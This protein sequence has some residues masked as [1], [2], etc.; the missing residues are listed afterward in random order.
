MDSRPAVLLV[1][2]MLIAMAAPTGAVA[3]GGA[4]S[5]ITLT[6]YPDGS[7]G[8][9]F[10]SNETSP[11]S[12]SASVSSF[13]VQASTAP[14][15]GGT[16]LNLQ[17]SAALS[18]SLTSQQPYSGATSFTAT[19]SY[20][21]GVASGSV[22]VQLVPGYS[23][24]LTSFELVYHGTSSSVTMGGNATV[25]YGTYTVNGQQVTVNQSVVSEFVN[26]F[27]QQVNA[28]SLNRELAAYNANVT[29]T[30]VTVSPTYSSNS[31]LVSLQFQATGDIAELPLFYFEAA[32]STVGPSQST[33]VPASEAAVF[34][35]YGEILSSFHDYTYNLAYSSGTASLNIKIDAASNLNIDQAI[36]TLSAGGAFTGETPSQSAFLSAT[37]F[38]ISNFNFRETGTVQTN[39]ESFVAVS[40]SGFLIRPPV[41]VVAGSFNESALFNFFATDMTG[42][43][44]VTLVAGSSSVTINDTAAPAPSSKTA[45]SVSW[46][47][48]QWG[49]LAGVRFTASAPGGG[50]V[51]EFPYQLPA[52]IFFTLAVV[53]AYMLARKQKGPGRPLSDPA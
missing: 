16:T 24:G 51:P 46:T 17:A 47:N 39:G 19:G 11:G 14:S 12:P 23:N 36:Q 32:A 35:A 5:S 41:T 52:T 43:V 42:P 28:S 31:A 13:S 34:R 49:E 26:T 30:S 20:S 8:V 27:Q 29:V 38:D 50:G 7:V 15:N 3:Q 9:A 6:V 25:Q 18:P 44:N 33:T 21:G 53:A 4:S 48:V 10:A 40:A 37:T 2:F 45:N 1:I 22:N